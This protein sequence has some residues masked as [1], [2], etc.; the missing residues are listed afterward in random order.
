MSGFIEVTLGGIGT[1][2]SASCELEGLSVRGCRFGGEEAAR[3][4]GG[5]GIGASES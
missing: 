5:D 1:T 3:L 2:G 4:R